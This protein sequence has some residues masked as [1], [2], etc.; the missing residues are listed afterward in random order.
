VPVEEPSTA[1]QADM[2]GVFALDDAPGMFAKSSF[3]KRQKA[4]KTGEKR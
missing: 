4:A 2:K 3:T 1:S